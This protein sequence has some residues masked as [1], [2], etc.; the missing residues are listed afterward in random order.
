MKPFD[1]IY[2]RHRATPWRADTGCSRRES[3][4]CTWWLATLLALALSSY[5]VERAAA[6]DDFQQRLTISNF[7][8]GGAD[9]T[10]AGEKAIV[11]G[12]RAL[13]QQ[14]QAV[15]QRDNKEVRLFSPECDLDQIS[16]T[17]QSRDRIHVRTRSLTIDGVGYDVSFPDQRIFI[18]NDVKVRIFASDKNLLGQ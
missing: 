8:L 2:N 17:G 15:F 1:R 10:V 4:S 13:I 6:N 9:Y 5:A 14:I 7:T 18:R 3:L 16:R 12:S 11:M